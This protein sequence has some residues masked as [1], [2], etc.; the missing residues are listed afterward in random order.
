MNYEFDFEKVCS[1]VK[2]NSRIPE[3]SAHKT[4]LADYLFSRTIAGM[5]SSEL[6]KNIERSSD[7]NITGRHFSFYP[8]RDINL[9]KWLANWMR[10]GVN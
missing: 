5:N 1:E 6:I 3:S 7:G 9:A 2:V 4:T 10:K 8:A